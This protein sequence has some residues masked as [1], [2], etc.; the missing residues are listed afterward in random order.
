M[1]KNFYR[2]VFNKTRGLFV[3][4]SEIVKSHQATTSCNRKAKKADIN[5]NLDNNTKFSTLKPLVFLSYV[6]LGMISIVGTSYAKSIVVDQSANQNQRPIV[7]ELQNG[8]TQINITAPS[9]N[10]VSHN[11]YTQF[12][13]SK[14]GVILNNATG[15]TN[16]QL[17]GIVNG[18]PLLQNSA[19]VILNE[20]N[21]NNISQLNGYI[22]VA[23]QK[24]QVVIA[25]PAG[26]TCDGCG[27]INAD[28][29]TLTT[30]KPIVTNG[31][32]DGYLVEKGQIQITGNGL[33]N[34][35]QDYSDLIARS[36]N[37]NA[38]LWANK[39][40]NVI[41][42][43]AKVSADLKHIDK[44]GIDNN[45][46]QPEFGIDV[47]RLGG[48]YADKIRMV[49]TEHGVGVRNNG[50][51]LANAG[52]LTVTNDGKV[53][54]A[55]YISSAQNLEF[56]TTY[57]GIENHSTI[58]S[59]K[60]IVLSSKAEIK[61][62]D[63]LNAQG[64]ITLNAESWVGNQGL[65]SSGK[66]ITTTSK[67]FD[68]S[69]SANIKAQ[70][71]KIDANM[72]KNTG[73]INVNDTINL[74]ANQFENNK[75]LAAKKEVTINSRKFK[76]DWKGKIESN[77]IKIFGDEFVN[78]GQLV[79]DNRLTMNVK[80]ITNLNEL[81]GRNEIRINSIE[82]SNKKDG[83]IN[84]YDAE[85]IT[86]NFD[87][88]GTILTG[89]LDISAEINYN[90][91]INGKII[92]DYFKLINPHKSVN[93]GLIDVGYFY[94][95]G[96]DFINTA[97]G[98]I[99]VGEL[100]ANNDYFENK[101]SVYSSSKIIVES[102]DF[103]NNGQFDAIKTLKVNQNKNFKNDWQGTI[104]ANL[105]DFDQQIVNESFSN[106]GSIQS[107]DQIKIKSKDFY[108]QGKILAKHELS[109]Q[110]DKLKNEMNASISADK[111][112]LSG[113]TLENKGLITAQDS[114]NIGVKQLYNKFKLLSDENLDI[115]TSYFSNE[116]NESIVKADL[117]TIF[118][119]KLDNHS[120]FNATND[121]Q[122]IVSNIYN[123]GRFTSNNH[124]GIYSADFKNDWAAHVDADKLDIAGGKMHNMNE[125]K[126]NR[127]ITINVSDF[128]NNKSLFTFGNLE[129][130]GTN[131]KNDWYGVIKAENLDILSTQLSNYGKFETS[132]LM[133]I[134]TKKFYNYGRV[135]SDMHIWLYA[136]YFRNDWK[137][138]M[139]ANY[140]KTK[141]TNIENYG[142][143][144]GIINDENQL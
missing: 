122:I 28:R 137:A 45:V 26:I 100:Y 21:S 124:I 113:T 99:K 36:V 1:N 52:T 3:V 64:D 101:G 12:D 44:Q 76:N 18:N 131:F 109:I 51:L 92:A 143:I 13:V 23:G 58:E 139:N 82:F 104:N 46:G 107:K 60:N 98:K 66:Q 42:G 118:A 61:N 70:N 37:I 16:T 121:L 97:F 142:S 54:N 135:D 55:G 47:S 6:A 129:I 9:K 87:S 15:G 50:T 140:I 115:N 111:I 65:I 8:T 10:G 49:G 95:L 68:N 136:D 14:K 130:G 103:Y 27:F 73:N 72:A 144:K 67:E 56:K 132:N 69:Y 30:G 96:S 31:N 78:Y 106:F 39:E 57:G 80:S 48:M 17:A 81:V 40:I 74:L 4:V 41:T 102:N 123:Q 93:E 141:V 7:K 105:I 84:A 71:L 85:V 120:T 89:A 35:G 108:N 20:V 86:Q 77:N 117:V 110:G 79:A 138:V 33:N 62:V 32:L 19:K 88:D 25:N 114:L 94:E 29:V 125:I 22:E 11:K 5:Q 63:R 83:I 59:S 127:Y 133:N 134:V 38:K 34:T 24:A 128:Y 53:I 90:N 75:K 116:G 43:K 91:G 119:D 2:I 112:D 126:A